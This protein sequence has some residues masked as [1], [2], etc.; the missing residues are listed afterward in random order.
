LCPARPLVSSR[1]RNNSRPETAETAEPSGGFTLIEVIIALTLSAVILS[2]VYGAVRLAW[3]A[4][5]RGERRMDASQHVR[6]LVDRIVPLIHSAYPL[7]RGKDDDRE[8]YFIGKSDSLGLVTSDVDRYRENPANLPGLRWIRLF[9]DSGGLNMEESYFYDAKA[10]E[11]DVAGKP[12][13]IDP[14]VKSVKFEYYEVK[15]DDKN[16]TWVDEWEPDD[17]KFE[18]PRAVRVSL[19]IEEDGKKINVPPIVARIYSWTPIEGGGISKKKI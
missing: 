1:N 10:L 15:E 2:I 19:V 11:G 6:T 3:R 17:D 14:Y 16:G 8:L 18:L 12:L 7:V 9:V 4:T 13:A 5:D